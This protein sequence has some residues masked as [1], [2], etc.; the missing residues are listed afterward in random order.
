M[1]GMCPAPEI[2][3]C[4]CWLLWTYEVWVGSGIFSQQ[5]H[6]TDWQDLV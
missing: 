3:H 5:L 2:G 1:R 6:C 4:Y